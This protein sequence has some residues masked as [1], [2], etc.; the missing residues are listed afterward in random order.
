MRKRLLIW[1]LMCAFGPIVWASNGSDFAS[2][3]VSYQGPFGPWPYNDPNAV[4]GLPTTHVYDG[5][6]KQKFT[7]SMVY[8]AWNVT[9]D[10]RP[11][12]LTLRPGSEVVVGFDHKVAD[13]INNPYGIDF[14][15][16]SNTFFTRNGGSLSPTSD[17]ATV[18]LTSPA[19]VNAEW[20]TV[21]VAQDPNGP[22]FVFPVEQAA[23][24]D[25]FPTHP[26]EWDRSTG[27]W[28]RPL[29]FL[30]PVNPN[31]T[32]SDFSGLS[33]PQAIALY[34]GSA[35]GTGFDL[36]WLDPA[37]FDALRVD[38]DTGRRW[39]QYVKLT[40]EEWGEADAVAD[41]AAC[42]D[43]RHPFPP[44]DVNKDC[45]VDL[46]DFAIL[47]EHWLICTWKCESEK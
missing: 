37:D 9:P 45:R 16:F 42:G 31:L 3:L 44:G 26:F 14:I 40:S 2:M 13:D 47:A 19:S 34:D 21:R 29:D 43:Y 35:G 10:G 41:V 22:W 17:M 20:L 33:V 24:G 18:T 7:I 6:E 46:A 11:T 1:S 30:K 32:L 4:L 27:W 36:Q 38:P 23:A 8:P 12:L 15:V 28:G 5:W 25:L 39:I